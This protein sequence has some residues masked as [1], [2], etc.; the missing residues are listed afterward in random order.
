MVLKAVF[1]RVALARIHGLGARRNAELARM[2]ND[3]AS[4]RRAAG[5][6]VPDDLGLVT[7]GEAS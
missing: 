1:N 2:A 6:D 5:R 3:F 7:N 4:E